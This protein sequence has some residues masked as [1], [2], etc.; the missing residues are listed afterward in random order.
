MSN[1]DRFADFL[2]D[3]ADLKTLG[4]WLYITKPY[5]TTDEIRYLANNGF[6]IGSHTRTHPM[7]TKL[8]FEE[9]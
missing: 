6:D 7:C 2:W 3:A 1:K 9:Y 4:S 8:N 5:M